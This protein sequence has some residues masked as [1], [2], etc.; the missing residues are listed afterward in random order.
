MSDACFG[1]FYQNQSSE[2]TNHRSLI[3]HGDGSSL[4]KLSKQSALPCIAS[5]VES[6]PPERDYQK[7]V[8]LV[9]SW[10]TKVKPDPNV[11]F[12]EPT[13]EPRLLIGTGTSIFI[14]GQ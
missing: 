3:I 4:V 13:G 10:T 5:L 8:V 9:S 2:I 1:E 14:N 6:P 7:N 12:Q 11:F